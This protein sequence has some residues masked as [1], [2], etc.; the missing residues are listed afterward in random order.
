MCHQAVPHGHIPSAQVHAVQGRSVLLQGLPAPSLEGAQ[1][2]LPVYGQSGHRAA[3][4][5]QVV[6]QD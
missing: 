3:P 5:G 1:A 6:L 2:A 4:T